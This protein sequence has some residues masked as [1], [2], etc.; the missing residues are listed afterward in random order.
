MSQAMRPKLCRE[1]AQVVFNRALPGDQYVIR[2]RAPGLA[3]GCRP[4]HFAQVDCGPTTTL[5]RPLSILDADAAAGTV[6]IF[7]KVVGRG[8][9]LMA[10]W[11]AGAEV[12]LMGPVGRTFTLIDAPK[13]AVLIGGGVGAAPVDFLARTLAGRGVECTLF[14]GMESE[15]PFVLEQAKQPLPGVERSIILALAPLQGAGVR[16]RMAALTPRQ[17]WF[18]GYVT[19]LAAAYLAAL[20]DQQREET[21]LY[22]CGPTPM[23]AAA[24]RVAKRFAL[25][26][27]AS[28]EEHM[29]CG[30][31]GCA[32][33]VAPIRV[34]GALGWN[35]RRVCVDGPV[36]DLDEIA[37]EQMGYAPAPVQACG[38]P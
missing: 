25:S 33:C 3:Q 34:G 21:V 36:F 14:L 17:G 15:S 2:L 5:P 32:G 8:T 6:D 23:M 7:Y 16:S 13:R 19:D 38:C 12:T 10:Q 9:E 24:N 4:G 30:F 35:Y 37:W 29:A 1:T 27:Q 11:Q 26:G 18:T 28:M 22:T 20:T 31:G